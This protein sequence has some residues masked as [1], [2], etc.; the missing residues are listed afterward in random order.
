MMLKETRQRWL[1]AAFIVISY[2]AASPLQAQTTLDRIVA[3]VGNEI[4]LESELN[5]NVQF[6]VFNNRVDPKTPG[7]KEKVLEVMVNEKLMLAKAIEDSIVV[8]EDEVNQELDRVIQQRVQQFGSEQQMVEAYG[9]PINRIKLEFRDEMRN[10]L[11]VSNLQRTRFGNINATRR[12]VEEFFEAYRDSLPRVPE[13][14]ELR[15]IFIVPKVDEKTKQRAHARAEAILDSIRAGGDFADFA[16]RSSQD[17]NSAA[18]GGDLGFVRRGALVPEFEEE[19][20]AL[21]EGE[22]SP[23]VETQFGFHIIELVERRGE[24]VHVRHILIKVQRDES[25]D[26][27]TITLLEGLKDSVIKHDASFADLAKRHSE[28]SETKSLGGSLGTL[29]VDQLDPDI[30]KALQPISRGGVSDPV[31]VHIGDSYGYHI[32]LLEN[33]ILEHAMNLTDDW[34]TVEG[35]ATSNKRTEQYND[36]LAELHNSIYWQ[37]RL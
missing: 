1:L 36:W 23:V 9:M 28:D 29:P 12:E 5:A 6:Y 27:E 31:R 4:V 18:Q 25:S 24:S 34:K 14:V 11:L 22:V 2:A 37:I 13:Q 15:H 32:F 7:L 26:R 10:Q 33:R 21:K 16:R 30:V 3:V 19:A 35:F 20:F 8:S 17:P